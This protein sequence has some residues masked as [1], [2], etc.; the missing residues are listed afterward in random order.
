VQLG[1]CYET[2]N[3]VEANADTAFDWYW[4]AARMENKEACY[5][6]GLMLLEGRGCKPNREK[7]AKWFKMAA[8]KNHVR[9]QRKLDEM[10]QSK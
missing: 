7:A 8:E 6:L 1:R 9:A 4:Q 5:R 3:G 2:G 10:N